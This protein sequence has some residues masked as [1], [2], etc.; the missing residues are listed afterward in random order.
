MIRFS[1]AVVLLLFAPL[2]AETVSNITFDP[3][4]SYAGLAKLQSVIGYL[5]LTTYLGI[6]GMRS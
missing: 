3:D 5:V 6:T 2:Y 1:I 4:V